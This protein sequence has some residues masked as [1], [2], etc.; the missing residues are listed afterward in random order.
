MEDAIV[1]ICPACGGT[2]EFDN[3][4]GYTCTECY[5]GLVVVEGKL[6]MGDD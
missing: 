2:V 4:L 5:A 6:E 1:L 3:D